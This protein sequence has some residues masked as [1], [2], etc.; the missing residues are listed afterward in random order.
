[1]SELLQ[2]PARWEAVAAGGALGAALALL[3]CFLSYTAAGAP[4]SVRRLA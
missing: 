2:T 1:M 4:W 3:N